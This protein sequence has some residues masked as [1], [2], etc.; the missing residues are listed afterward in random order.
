MSDPGTTYRTREEVGGVR[1][2]RDPIDY[3]KKTLIEYEMATEK[4]I[5]EIEKEIRNDVQEAL[6]R[7]KAGQPAGFEHLYKEV[8]AKVGNCRLL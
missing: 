7:A 6:V 1:Q 2:A 5:K 4:E 8:Y 3:V